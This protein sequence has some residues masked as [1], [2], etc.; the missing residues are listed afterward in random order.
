MKIGAG[1][2]HSSQGAGDRAG[3]KE[4]LVFGQSGHT[5]YADRRTAVWQSADLRTEKEVST[6]SCDYLYLDFSDRTRHS[7]CCTGQC[8]SRELFD[9]SSFL[10]LALPS[11]GM[12][13]LAIAFLLFRPFIKR[14]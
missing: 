4:R 2:R 5:D 3:Y 11:P 6:S 9:F 14:T 10:H 12:S 13:P 8:F 1:P 7:E